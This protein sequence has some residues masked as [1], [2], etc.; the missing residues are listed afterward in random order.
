MF[1]KK[2]IKMKIILK[3]LGILMVS[4]MI[5]FPQSSLLAQTEEPYLTLHNLLEIAVTNYPLLKSKRL[6]E[7][8][9]QKS[10]SAI[11]SSI[12]PSLDASYQV[13][14]GTYNN[15]I[16]MVY[17]QFIIP[18]SGPPSKGNDYNGV[19]GSAASLLINWQPITFGQRR[20]QVDFARAGLEYADADAQNEIF[21]HK[22]KVIDAYLDILTASELVK[23]YQNNLGRQEASLKAVY[24]LVNSGIKPGVDTSLFKAEVSKAKVDL[25]N[26]QKYK[27]QTRIILSRLLASD[28]NYLFS[29]TLF[30]FKL[31]VNP[32]V[33]DSNRNPVVNL[34][35]TNFEIS[36][37]RKKVLTRTLLPALGVWGTTYARGS[38][39]SYDGSVNSESGLTFQRYNYGVGLQL[40]MPLLQF[41]RIRPQ[42]Q[43]Q[44]FLIQS[45]QEKLNDIELQ[46]KKQNELAEYTVRNAF[47]VVKESPLF[48]ESAKFS[49]DAMQSRYQSG[50]ANFTDFMQVQYALVKAETDYKL[51]YM[52]VWKALLYKAAVSG[53]LDLFINQVN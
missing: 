46:V 31:P 39:I 32:V 4:T 23:V 33:E 11:K 53:N 43:Q 28:N 17:P 45:N 13:N 34:Y 47:A 44:E 25:L 12:I 7:Q 16:G 6:D 41:A 48:L 21:Q 40:S 29:D 50:L 51:S 36:V 22:I 38:G 42:L 9:A 49:F 30:F 35:R 52:A 5:L 37:A 10:V 14:Y 27:E 1:K 19:Y 20:G 15:I 2:K 8:A 26:S 24:S 3:C 18:I